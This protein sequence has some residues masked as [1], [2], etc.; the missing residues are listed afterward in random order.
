MSYRRRVRVLVLGGT[1][2]I[3]PDVLRELVARG[4]EVAIFHRG[5]SEPDGLPEVRHIH[6]DRDRLGDHR[7]TLL[8]LRPEVALD[9]RPLVERD[10]EISLRALRGVVPRLVAI[11]SADVYLAYGRLH[12]TE[13]GPP[14]AMPLKEDAPLREK[15]Y[16]YRGELGKRLGGAPWLD[17]VL[18]YA[19]RDEL[20]RR[21]AAVG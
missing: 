17:G 3:G 21:L 7:E 10:A 20:L 2:F 12:G 13:P 18:D 1:G 19:A 6:G 11:S 8:A 16:P 15:L 4:H 5:Q 9:L 14:L